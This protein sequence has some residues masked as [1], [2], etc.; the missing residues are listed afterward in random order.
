MPSDRRR[1]WPGTVI[2]DP[3]GL[4]RGPRPL[5]NQRKLCYDARFSGNG[6]W[7]L[8]TVQEADR[9]A[10]A[11]LFA[12]CSPE[13]IRLRFFGGL[14]EL[15]RR[16][17]ADVLAGR[18]EAHDAVVARH[19]TEGQVAGLASLAAGS[20]AGP[21]I[22][23]LGVLVADTWQRQGLGAAMVDL[24]LLLVRARERGVERMSACVLPGRSELLAALA[25][26]LEM[27][28]SFH[29]SHSLTGVYKLG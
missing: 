28:R 11:A 19:C 22:P 10:L 21:G 25:R 2:V 1:G 26:R 4:A 7:R 13:T 14:N 3:R 24:L 16:Y 20:E 12:S 18:P 9:D 6:P 17:L 23:E 27:D 8:D 29:T 5:T 15:P